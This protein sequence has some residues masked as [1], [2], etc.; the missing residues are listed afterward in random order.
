MKWTARGLRLF[1]DVVNRMSEEDLY[2]VLPVLMHSLECSGYVEKLSYAIPEEAIFLLSRIEGLFPEHRAYV[3]TDA[4]G[5]EYLAIKRLGGYDFY[6]IAL[7]E[8]G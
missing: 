1:L 2:H 7:E 5:G 4:K 3:I 6:K 8:E